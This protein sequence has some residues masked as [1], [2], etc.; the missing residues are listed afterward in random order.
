M[1]LLVPNTK[2]VVP[3]GL[4]LGTCSG[5]HAWHNKYYVRRMRVGKNESI[6]SYLAI[7]H[8]EL[9]E[10]DYFRPHDTAVISIPQQA[11]KGS[12]VR[13]EKFMDLL[14]RI[15][16]VATEW[17]KP[18]H[19]TGSNSHNVSAT[20]S[21]KENEWDA[22]GE[23]MWKNRDHYNGLAV[24]PYDGGSYVQA[25]FED[26]TKQKYDEMSRTLQNVDLTKVIEL[27]DKTD[28]SGELACA[29]GNCEI[30]SL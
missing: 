8:P 22:A 26:I 15:K 10:D 30:T 18:G 17:V 2:L 16:K 23:W 19:K 11:P 28:L 24:L 1:P 6:Y 4:V 20:V 29:G 27:E 7:H 9:L 25:P 3:A 21:L 13:T 14:E 5:I 12:I